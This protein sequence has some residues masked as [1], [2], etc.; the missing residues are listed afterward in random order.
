MPALAALGTI[1]SFAPRVHAVA[2]RDLPTPVYGTGGSTPK[3]LIGK[4]GAALAAATPALTIVYQSPGACHGINSVAG[5]VKLTGTASYWDATGKELTCDLPVTGEPVQFGN[6]GNS[7]TLCPGVDKLPDNVGDYLGPINSTSIIVPN[8][9]SQL[10]ISAAGAYFVFGFGAAGNVA[11]WTDEAQ[12]IKRDSSS[13][14]LLAIAFSAGIPAEKFKGVDAKTNGNTVTLVSSSPKPESAIGFV[15]S[16]IADAA[17][18]KVRELAFQA[19]GQT[20]GYWP[21]STSTSFDKRNVRTGQYFI[22]SPLHFFT[23]LDAA[24]NPVYPAAKL[25]IDYFTLAKPAPA[26]VDILEL[27]IKSGTIPSC[28]MEVQR[29]GDYG[30]LESYAPAEPCGCYFDKVATGTTTCQACTKDPECPGGAPH[31]RFGFCEVN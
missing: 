2:C 19:K 15:S 18:D 27:S 16:E 14:A 17:R 20:C 4:V 26:G 1:A 21:D 29:K 13:G 24:K 7:A 3:P 25:L 12:I 30:P 10:S 8:A 5:D 9:S 23:K 11:P 28:A 31:C 22:W 6:M